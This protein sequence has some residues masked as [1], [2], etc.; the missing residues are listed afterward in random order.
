MKKLS[1]ELTQAEA[2]VLF[3]WLTRNDKADR[4]GVDDDSEQRVLWSVE[5]QLEK[6]L[7]ETLAPN[8]SELLA[9]ARSQVRDQ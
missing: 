4:L 3:E 8:Y 9:A 7:V 5:A 6:Q 1:L 2:L